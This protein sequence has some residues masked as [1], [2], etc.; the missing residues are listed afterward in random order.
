MPELPEVETIKLGLQGQVVGQTIKKIEVLTPKS[1][2]GDPRNVNG[3]KISNVFRRAKM[4]GVELGNSWIVLFHLKM[5]GQIILV[6]NR[7]RFVGGHPTSDIQGEMPNNSTRVIFE[8]DNGSKIYFND[9]RKFGWVK[10]ISSK[11]IANSFNSLGPEPLEETFTLDV[12]KSQLQ[13]RKNTPVKVVIMDQTV[14]AGV[15]NIYACEALFMANILPTRRIKDLT[16]KEVSKLHQAI[17]DVLT[18]GI[19]HG[20]SSRSHYVNSEGKKGHFLDFA[21]V[22]NRSGESCRT[23]QEVI[24]KT[25]VGGRGTFFCRFCQR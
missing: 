16:P 4:L 6:S 20:G 23:C 15:G 8:L 17:V 11:L 3:Q 9:Q 19:K 13:K 22:Y 18:L 2:Q 5:T 14:V 1:F 10:A 21:F 25:V 24:N 12:F 7:A